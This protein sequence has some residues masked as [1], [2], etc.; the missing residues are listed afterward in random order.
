MDPSSPFDEDATDNPDDDDNVWSV[1]I[2]EAFEEALA[3]Y[4]PTG[5]RKIVL[6][7]EGK[8]YGL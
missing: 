5:R 8:A 3:L 1:D 4:P 2:E 7:A 6:S